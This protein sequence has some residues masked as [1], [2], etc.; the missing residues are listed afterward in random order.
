MRVLKRH[1]AALPIVPIRTPGWETRLSDLLDEMRHRPMAWGS[2]DCLTRVADAC[3]VMTGVDP[4]LPLRGAYASEADALKLLAARGHQGLAE[5]LAEAF[6]EI[7]PAMARRGD[8]GVVDLPMGPAAVIFE[9]SE[10]SGVHSKGTTLLSRLRVSRAFR[11][12]A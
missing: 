1:K 12:G 11:V 10:V 8:C 3:L 6:P 2:N 4:M 5:A 7:A 9:G